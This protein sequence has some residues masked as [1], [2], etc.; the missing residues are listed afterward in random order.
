MVLDVELGWTNA[1]CAARRLVLVDVWIGS[2][3]SV[4]IGFS[5]RLNVTFFSMSLGFSIDDWSLWSLVVDDNTWDVDDCSEW[6]RT[7]SC[8]LVLVVLLIYVIVMLCRYYYYL[9]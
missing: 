4:S 6:M 7:S 3:V 8:L 9:I 2:E 5:E 1:E